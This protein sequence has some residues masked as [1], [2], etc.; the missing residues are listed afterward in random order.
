MYC[1]I[2]VVEN[3]HFLCY[4]GI[5]AQI[6]EH[7][8]EHL[9]KLSRIASGSD[10]VREKKIL[11]DLSQILDHFNELQEVDTDAVEPL[12]GGTDVHSVYHADDSVY[13]ADAHEREREHILSQFPEHE[14]GY[15]KVP[16]IFE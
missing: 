6:D 15:L 9:Y 13:D 11:K 1:T 2:M 8:L 5:M 16:P 12:A 10:E 3:S 4:D 7:T 14:R